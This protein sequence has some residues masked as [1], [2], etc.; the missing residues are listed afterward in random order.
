MAEAP[1]RHLAAATIT[2]AL[3]GFS[4]GAWWAN[5]RARRKEKARKRLMQMAKV[6]P[7][8]VALYKRHH[9]GVWPEVEKG[10][11]KVGVETISIWSDPS[12]DCALYMYLEMAE[13]AGDMAEGS[14]YR[15]DPRVREWERAMETE[16]HAGWKPLSEWYTLKCSGSKTVEVSTNSLLQRHRREVRLRPLGT[17]QASSAEG[18][19]RCRDLRGRKKEQRMK[20]P[21]L[22]PVRAGKARIESSVVDSIRHIR[23]PP[24]GT[25]YSPTVYAEAWT[26]NAAL[27]RKIPLD[28]RISGN[29]PSGWTTTEGSTYETN[30]YGLVGGLG[31]M[32]VK[33]YGTDWSNPAVTVIGENS[34]GTIQNWV[35]PDDWLCSGYTLLDLRMG[36]ME[37]SKVWDAM[38]AESSGMTWLLRLLGWIIAW[39]AFCLL[40]G[41][42]EVA[43]DCIPCI[44]PCLGNMVS[45]V[46]CVVSCLPATACTLGVVGVV[47][48][49]MRPMVGIP[50]LCIFIIV[51]VAFIVWKVFFAK[52][53]GKVYDSEQSGQLVEGNV[54]GNPVE[55]PASNQ[56]EAPAPKGYSGPVEEEVA[57]N[58]LEALRAE[59]VNGQGGA[60]G[61]FFESNGNAEGALAPLEDE[62]RAAGDK[63]AAV[64]ALARR[65]GL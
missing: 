5:R 19:E 23:V 39:V 31:N 21:E 50:L 20:T 37:I 29:A 46:I 22:W 41:P 59:Y 42:L 60:V 14:Q 10:L 1:W 26:L 13:D 30:Q 61:G 4:C 49:V 16:F 32:K 24:T 6:R 47:W 51:M 7:D 55:A 62:V 27:I 33:F 28:T 3:L 15:D 2:S 65:W 48:V 57:Q 25:Y 12:D 56:V 34:G 11:A 64:N 35:A 36:T 54:V 38:R 53:G 18:L 63:N 40:A 52:K 44:G 58:F 8:R 17:S 45:T 43:A 9:Q